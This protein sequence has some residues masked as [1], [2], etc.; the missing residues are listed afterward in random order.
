MYESHAIFFISVFSNIN[1]AAVDIFEVADT[2][3]TVQSVCNV[4]KLILVA[5]GRQVAT[6]SLFRA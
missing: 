3:A 4:V 5:T 6:Y 1:M 2:S